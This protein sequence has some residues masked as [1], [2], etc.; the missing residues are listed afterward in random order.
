MQSCLFGCVKAVF[1]DLFGDLVGHPRGDLGDA[2]AC[3]PRRLLTVR[4]RNHQSQSTGFLCGAQQFGEVP[5]PGLFTSHEHH[6]VGGEV[7]NTAINLF[8]PIS[9]LW[10]DA[11]SRCGRVIE[12]FRESDRECIRGSRGHPGSS[13]SFHEHLV[14]QAQHI[15]LP[16]SKRKRRIRKRHLRANLGEVFH[17]VFRALLSDHALIAIGDQV[18]ATEHRNRHDD[19]GYPKS[20][21]DY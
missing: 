3:K 5:L 2:G 14:F 21:H 7:G 16:V 6:P 11:L 17:P 18:V 4:D 15:L 12:A 13:P 10:T 9:G 1:L 8:E 19:N 20:F